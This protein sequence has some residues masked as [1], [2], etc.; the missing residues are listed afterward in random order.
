MQ[1]DRPR[2]L[3]AL[4]AFSHDLARASPYPVVAARDVSRLAALAKQVVDDVAGWADRMTALD[5]AA[6]FNADRALL[7]VLESVFDEVLTP[8]AC[9]VLEA[10]MVLLRG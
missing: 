8:D 7:L 6:A 9:R 2:R 3:A 4:D 10:E 5:C 1:S